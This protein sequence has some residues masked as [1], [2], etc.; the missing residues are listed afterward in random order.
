MP[1]A[2]G[3]A[4]GIAAAGS[5]GVAVGGGADVGGW[6]W[7]VASAVSGWVVAVAG[8]VDA[9]GVVVVVVVAVMATMWGIEVEV[10]LV[11]GY[12]AHC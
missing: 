2:V 12:G 8:D 11:D 9:A 6:G 1:V 5:A 4:A 7:E 3:T 10:G